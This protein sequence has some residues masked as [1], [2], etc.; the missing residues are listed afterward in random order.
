[1]RW[2]RIAAGVALAFSLA[3]WAS[4]S[5]LDLADPTPRWIE[6]RFEVSPADEPGSID[7]AWSPYRRAWLRPAVGNGAIEIRVPPEEVEAQLRSTGT[8]TV[9][10]SFSAFVWRLD[11]DTGHVLDAGLTGRVREQVQLG[12]FRRTTEV[13]IDV[14]M[15]TVARAGYVSSSGALGIETHAWCEPTTR[16][17]RCKEVPAVPFDRTRGY[18]NAV[19]MLRASAG[20]FELRAF[21]PLGEVEFRERATA[22]RESVVVGGPLGDG[23]CSA[24]GRGVCPAGLGEES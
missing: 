1:M 19:G 3:A 7:R 14:A 18:V 13:A 8:D 21:S 15:T 20:V 5:P 16:P 23:V 22:P 6:V 17:T 9:E 12:P 10:G 24:G 11:R 2:H 4:A